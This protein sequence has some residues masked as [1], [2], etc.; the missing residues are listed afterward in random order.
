MPAN[1]NSHLWAFLP[2]TNS[3]L[4]S[5][6]LAF[7][8]LLYLGIGLRGLMT[9]F[10]HMDTSKPFS[11]FFSFAIDGLWLAIAVGLWFMKRWAYR[12]ANLFGLFLMA[13]PIGFFNSSA[14]IDL[15]GAHPGADLSV[16]AIV[17]I[18]CAWIGFWFVILYRLGKCK[19]EFHKAA[20]D[21]RSVS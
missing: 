16:G 6:I 10:A 7:L 19:D 4:L 8:I 12:L 17:T 11:F 13:A 1:P 15:R 21:P 14:A 20:M 2:K 18:V 9:T 3:K 5:W